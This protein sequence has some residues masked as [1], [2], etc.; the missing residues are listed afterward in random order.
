MADLAFHRYADA[1]VQLD[2]RLA[3]MLAGAADLHL[4][5]GNRAPALR[6]EVLRQHPHLGIGLKLRARREAGNDASLPVALHQTE[7]QPVQHRAA[8]LRLPLGQCG[9]RVAADGAGHTAHPAIG[10]EREKVAVLALF[11]L[12]QCHLQQGSGAAACSDNFPT[13]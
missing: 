2:R 8:R 5:R 1:A 10:R 7:H 9:A 13:S 11:Q 3:D 4:C 6:R 12:S